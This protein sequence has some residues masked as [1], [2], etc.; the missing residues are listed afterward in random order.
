[1]QQSGAAESDEYSNLDQMP[2][3][4]KWVL[5]EKSEV[6][7]RSYTQEFLVTVMVPMFIMLL[8]ALVISFILCFHH[9]GM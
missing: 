5:I 4:D 3:E 2:V 6:P 1:M 8:L 9:E 7:Q